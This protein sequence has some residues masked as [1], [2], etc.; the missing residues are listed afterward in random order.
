MVLGVNDQYYIREMPVAKGALK[1]YSV[2]TPLDPMAPELA[3][4]KT[5][6]IPVYLERGDGLTPMQIV[7]NE[8][9]VLKALSDIDGIPKLAGSFTY[10]SQKPHGLC[11][12]VIIET[13]CGTSTLDKHA[14]LPIDKKDALA[15][16]TIRILDDI[17]RRGFAHGDIK[18]DN[19]LLKD[20]SISVI[21]FGTAHHFSEPVIGGT[22]LFSSPE[23]L[24]GYGDT[25]ESDVFSLG[26]SLTSL[27]YPEGYSYFSRLPK[28]MD[29]DRRQGFLINGL[30][31][32]GS[33]KDADSKKQ[34]NVIQRM[35]ASDPQRRLSLRQALEAIAAV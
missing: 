5:K 21:D 9:K 26:L 23:K 10:T 6:S 28:T 25:P 13:N 18:P 30:R 19:I 15:V 8:C 20:S 3:F 24:A 31:S 35:I 7:R 2:L 27:Y 11:R 14:T 34:I 29:V 22:E 32:I 12:S 17:H 4:L 16:K 33:D 1:T